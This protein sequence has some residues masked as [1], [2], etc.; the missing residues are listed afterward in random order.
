MLWGAGR[1]LVRALLSAQPAVLASSRKLKHL[2]SSSD[3]RRARRL[4]TAVLVLGL[5]G[6]GRP[7]LVSLNES[8]LPS[9]SGSSETADEASLRAAAYGGGA[10]WM[11][12][13]RIDGREAVL[14]P[15]PAAEKRTALL[16]GINR[17]AGGRPLA[18][19]VTDAEHMRDALLGY[20]FP[21]ANIKMLLDG[22]A[23]KAAIE[24]ELAAL[25]E[26]SPADGV[27]VFA[28]ATHTRKHRGQNELLTA[29]GG[30]ISAAELGTALGRVRSKM[31]VALPTCYAAG[32]AVPGIVG[33]GRVATFASPSTQPTYQLGSAG[34]YLVINMVR[35]AMLEGHATGSVEASFRWAEAT[36]RK[37]HPDRVPII[38]DGV[39]GELVLG[40]MSE[41]MLA[42]YDQVRRTE[43]RRHSDDDPFGAPNDPEAE[44]P[45]ADAP[46]G[47]EDAGGPPTRRSGIAVCGPVSY[48][49]SSDD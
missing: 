25:A 41:E 10:G 6:P 28:V 16:I 45:D 3:P 12:S 4:A 13:I 1:L 18:G 38:D 20:G 31:W 14:P 19:S 17:A 39:E 43:A 35:E 34:S 8:P 46:E 7:L 42:R 33:K 30:R 9:R 32:Y 5:L 23:T 24:R 40:R 11:A 21:R 2:I 26:R 48:R 44:A 22:Q 49:C 47:S 36:L 37:A 27:A 29:D 15:A